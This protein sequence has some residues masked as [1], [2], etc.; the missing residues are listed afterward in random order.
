MSALLRV[1]GVAG[2]RVES[3]GG[4]PGTLRLDLASGADEVHVAS[5][6]NALLRDRFGLAVDPNGV[7]VLGDGTPA[8]GPLTDP[9]L[10]E[11]NGTQPASDVQPAQAA[12]AVETRHRTSSPVREPDPDPE[13]LSIDRL[14]LSSAGLATTVIVTLSR[15]GKPY[16]G[17]AQGT[18]TAESLNRAVATATLRAVEAVAGD[19]VRFEL[20][21]VE[22]AQT[23]G[24]HT[25][26]A[27]VTMV[28]ERVTQ[29]LTGASVVREDVRQAVIRAVLAAVNRQVPTVLPDPPA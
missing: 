1:P 18:A 3:D 6:V 24:E 16:D 19:A 10:P 14:R 29:R 15:H 22:I 11:H 13:R 5:E 7:R 21:H 4:G 20:D 23:P 27:V 9:D 12:P 2:A 17:S 26:L 25:A 28:T 8:A